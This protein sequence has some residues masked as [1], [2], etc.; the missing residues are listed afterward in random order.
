[1][2]V[3]KVDRHTGE[4]AVAEISIQTA[5]NACRTV[6]KE[7]N[8]DKSTSMSLYDALV[9]TYEWRSAED[10]AS[11]EEFLSSHLN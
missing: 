8:R 7:L 5:S 1:M 6:L 4:A 2:S 11:A 10:S 9:L 3:T